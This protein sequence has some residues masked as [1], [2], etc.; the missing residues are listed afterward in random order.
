MA[1]TRKKAAQ[2]EPAADTSF[3]PAQ[4]DQPQ[5]AEQIV[6]SVA[7]STRLPD[8]PATHAPETGHADRV[9]RREPV[10]VNS[11]L[12]FHRSDVL[13]GVKQGEGFRVV[14]NIKVREAVL[15][16][17]EKPSPEVIATM[18]DANFAWSSADKLWVLPIRRDSGWQD[19]AHADATFEAVSKQIRTERG[20]THS[21]GMT[22]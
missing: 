1:R 10:L 21:V 6:H 14:N 2:A 15:A 19:R 11:G 17:A 13:A 9:T 7:D 3:D 18:K 16:F 12:T 20:I 22:A 8:L 4:F 5:T